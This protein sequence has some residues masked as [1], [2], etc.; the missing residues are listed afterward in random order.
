M[1]A[2][3]D[4]AM[5]AA[6]A[7]GANAL[8]NK[9]SDAWDAAHGEPQPEDIKQE[10][11]DVKV[12]LAAALRIL[13]DL[14]SVQRPLEE[15]IHSIPA[16]PAYLALK[17]KDYLYQMIWSAGPLSLLV[18][19]PGMA[20]GQAYQLVAGWNVVSFPDGA[21]LY[22]AAGAA[23]VNVRIR[24]TDN[25]QPV[26]IP[27]DAPGEAVAGI[28]N[29][30]APALVNGQLAQL[31]LD[32]SGNLQTNL[33]TYISGEDPTLTDLAANGVMVAQPRNNK[34]LITTNN[35]TNGNPKASVCYLAAL[36]ITDPGSSWVINIYDANSAIG[37]PIVV[38]PTAP[39]TLLFFG[40]KMTTG[41]FVTTSG[42]VAG[43]AVLLYD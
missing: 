20:G 24:L 23:A 13:G 28:Y 5:G 29:L 4:F 8:G 10:V 22:L 33:N 42:T 43:T 3:L 41:I 37:T 16:S 1:H 14:R 11:A 39:T 25:V 12:M 15:D 6:G 7:I 21:R 27:S 38:K 34:Y 30:V 9:A 26:S 19:M 2:M 17:T 40:A 36:V 32:A 35:L 18:D 31:Q